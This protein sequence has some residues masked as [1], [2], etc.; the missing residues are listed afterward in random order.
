MKGHSTFV[1]CDACAQPVAEQTA[2]E[3]LY[4]VEKLRYLLKLCSTCLDDEM[5]RHDS[6][7]SIPGMHKRAAIA[8][9]IPSADDLPKRVSTR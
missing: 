9:T 4:Q 1:L 2:K 3:V 7:R 5:R 8:F 6:L